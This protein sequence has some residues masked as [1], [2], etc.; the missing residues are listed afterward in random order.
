MASVILQGDAAVTQYRYPMP[1]PGVPEFSGTYED[2][3]VY[4]LA[5]AVDFKP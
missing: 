3:R 1:L 4:A 5:L 2:T